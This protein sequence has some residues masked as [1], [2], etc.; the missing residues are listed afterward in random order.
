[1]RRSGITSRSKCASF[2]R[3]Q[4]SWSNAGPRRPGGH[5]VLVVDDRGAGVG[6]QRF[7]R[8]FS[9]PSLVV[10]RPRPGRS[11]WRRRRRRSTRAPGA[12]SSRQARPADAVHDDGPVVDP[13]P[14]P[15]PCRQRGLIDAFPLEVNDFL[16]LAADQVVMPRRGGLESSLALDGLDPADEPVRRQG[17]QGPVDGVQ[18]DPRVPPAQAPV[19]RFGRRMVRD[20]TSTR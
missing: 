7:L 18:R 20:E 5:D 2:S 11:G 15:D 12:A 9:A 10:T 13:S 19:Q 16:A 14:G 8:H 17:G 6:G 1:M 3:N 4:T